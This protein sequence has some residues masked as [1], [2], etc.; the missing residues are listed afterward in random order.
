MTEKVKM[1]VIPT[2]EKNSKGETVF[3][4]L[5]LRRTEKELEEKNKIVFDVSCNYFV[6][7]DKKLLNN[8]KE[9]NIAHPS[10]D[11]PS[12]DEIFVGGG[13]GGFGDRVI[14]DENSDLMYEQSNTQSCFDI[15][16]QLPNAGRSGRAPRS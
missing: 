12:S 11:L 13:S 14:R 8:I 3:S 6:R 5:G 7:E 9:K 16:H 15:S 1:E 2:S 4:F 10:R